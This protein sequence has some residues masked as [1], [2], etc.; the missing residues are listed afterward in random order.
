MDAKRA[1]ELLRPYGGESPDMARFIEFRASD[2]ARL[3]VSV[4]AIH[5]LVEHR[6][7]ECK[8]HY[9]R[10]VVTLRGHY[11][12]LKAEVIDAAEADEAEPPHKTV[13]G[14]AAARRTTLEQESCEDASG[15]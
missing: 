4:D 1:N 10:Q 6:A 12:K 3:L 14:F 5:S 11:G 2:G 8:L 15:S 7:G 13:R 9:A